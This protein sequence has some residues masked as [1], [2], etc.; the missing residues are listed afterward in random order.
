MTN[1]SLQRYRNLISNIRNWPRYFAQKN[2]KTFAPVT[3]TTRSGISFE[4]PTRELY[5]VFKEIFLTDFYSVSDWVDKLP[6][7]PVIVDIGANA[8]Y[9]SVLL[10]SKRPDASIYAYEPIE[11][12]YTLFGDNIRRNVAMSGHVHLFHRAVTGKPVD[13]ITLY[14]EADSDNSVTAS[15]YQDFESHNLTEVKVK[16]ISLGEIM[17]SNKLTQI[18]F[19]KLDCEGSEYPI[20]Y[21]SDDSIW[22]KINSIFLEVHNL[23]EDRRNFKAMKQFLEQHGYRTSEQLA[24][25]G[26]YALF[27]RR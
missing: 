27:A 21:E 22:G 17:E 8:G 15:V 23:D 18:D 7:H 4:V 2:D 1:S 3:F 12:N 9:F 5:L 11:R 13:E 10:M 14:K 6:S 24:S 25:N 20:V 19:L 16:A 26:C